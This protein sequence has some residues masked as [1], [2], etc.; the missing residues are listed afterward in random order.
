MKAAILSGV[1]VVLAFLCAGD[2]LLL[3]V[4]LLLARGRRYSRLFIWCFVGL[5]FAFA[6]STLGLVHYGRVLEASVE[7]IPDGASLSEVFAALGSPTE[8]RQETVTSPLRPPANVVV[9]YFRISGFPFAQQRVF[10]F[11]D[12]KLI[13]KRDH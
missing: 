10:E 1:Y 8:K 5:L 6:I 3:C 13:S 12:G 9:W 11:V 7:S 2:L 4:S